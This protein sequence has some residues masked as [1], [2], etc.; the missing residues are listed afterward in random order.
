M[1]LLEKLRAFA[2]SKEFIESRN[3]YYDYHI[4]SKTN[5][6]EKI[7]LDFTL[8]NDITDEIIRFGK[9]E[10]CGICI[11]HKDFQNNSF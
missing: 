2:Q 4:C 6:K 8:S 5:E 10:K 1:D 9:C 7:S 11:Y 3:Y